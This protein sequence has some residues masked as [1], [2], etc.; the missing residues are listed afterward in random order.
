MHVQVL[1]VRLTEFEKDDIKS[2]ATTILFLPT[3]LTKRF[4][5]LVV[6]C[7]DHGSDCPSPG[8]DILGPSLHP[9]IL[10]SYAL[11]W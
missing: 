7:E 10:F 11:K 9:R 2:F 4:F 3:C 1:Q 6:M 5:P 8:L